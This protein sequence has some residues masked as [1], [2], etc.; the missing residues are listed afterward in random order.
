MDQDPD[1]RQSRSVQPSIDKWL[2]GGRFAHSLNSRDAASRRRLGQLPVGVFVETMLTDSDAAARLLRDESLTTDIT[3]G[4]MS[5]PGLRRLRSALMSSASAHDT[6]HEWTALR[7]DQL[8]ECLDDSAVRLDD[9]HGTREV[10]AGNGVSGRRYA[11]LAALATAAMIGVLGLQSWLVNDSASDTSLP[12]DPSLSAEFGVLLD[13]PEPES[14]PERGLEIEPSRESGTDSSVPS[15]LAG[16]GIGATAWSHYLNVALETGYI[17]E[18]MLAYPENLESVGLTALAQCEYLDD[19][20]PEQLAQAESD[21][22][23][24]PYDTAVRWFR[25]AAALCNASNL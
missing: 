22:F 2:T 6:W 1:K 19:G 9:L 14:E 17:T 23:G 3:L 24:T 20:S 13:P 5:S 25:A 21:D 11:F 16:Y 4:D 7:T 8:F 15:A 18:D 12:A 10:A